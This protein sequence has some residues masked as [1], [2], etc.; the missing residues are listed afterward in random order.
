MTRGR[1]A[2]TLSWALVLAGCVVVDSPSSS[3]PKTSG[4]TSTQSL[5]VPPQETQPPSNSQ[6][7]S[8]AAPSTS[9]GPEPGEFFE[10][11][12]TGPEEN[13]LEYLLANLVIEPEWPSGYSR[14]LFR[15]WV[16]ADGDGCNTRRE[17]LILEST[18]PVT[19]GANC[20]VSGKWLSLYDLVETTDASSFDI[21]HMVPLK[22]AWDSGAH[23]WDSGTRRA[24]ANDLGFEHTLIAVTASSN[25]SKGEKDPADWL[26]PNRSYHC[27]YA[28]KWMATKY[29]WS[30]SIDQAEA[31]SL[32]GL[33][34]SCPVI[35]RELPAVAFSE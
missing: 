21:D 2:L 25:R 23:A 6:S 31:L 33:V 26:P 19:I 10:S 11:A 8:P 34:A 4:R 24:F 16:D 13:P 17:V 12:A 30:L 3:T 1:I 20:S 27:D 35:E 32:G 5:E 28:Y 18:E 7:A 29:R 14:D 15:H 22:E 9:A